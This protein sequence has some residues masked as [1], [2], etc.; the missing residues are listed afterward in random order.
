MNPPLI[1]K[2]RPGDEIAVHESHMR[3]IRE[4]CIKD[5]GEDEVRG[6]GNRPLGDR[7]V[8]A[9][10]NDHVWVVELNGQIEGH[11]Y[12]RI[13]EDAGRTVAHIHGLYL[14]PAVLGRGLGRQLTKLML[15]T[16]R[17][18]NAAE[19]TLDSTVTAH[20]FYKSFG[21]V[22]CAPMRHATIGGSAVRCFPMRL[23]LAT[24]RAVTT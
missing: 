7:W 9:I 5:H 4:V 1:R 8:Q 12:I 11:G 20:E 18:H 6:W 3:S 23:D 24:G 19:V 21:F 15:D 22:D 2:A 14:T 17:K 10:L 16:A 13:F